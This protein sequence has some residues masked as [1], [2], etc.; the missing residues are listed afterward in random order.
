[1]LDNPT[2]KSID[3]A[4]MVLSI[5]A[6]TII[7]WL[8]VTSSFFEELNPHTFSTYLSVSVTLLTAFSLIICTYSLIF[9][10]QEH[11]YRDLL[12]SLAALNVGID[13]F[14]YWM[15]HPN[16]PF[17]RIIEVSEIKSD[18]L[19]ILGIGVFIFAIVVNSIIGTRSVPVGLER[20]TLI[21]GGLILPVAA[22][23]I[24]AIEYQILMLQFNQALLNLLGD[25]ILILLASILGISLILSLRTWGARNSFLDTSRIFLCFFIEIFLVLRL[26]Q[27]QI[28][29]AIEL[30]A[31]N[32]AL[33][34]FAIYAAST[35]ILSIVEPHRALS[36][37]VDARTRELEISRQESEFYLFMW[38]HDVGNTLQSIASYLELLPRMTSLDDPT[39]HLHRTATELTDKATDIVRLVNQLTQIRSKQSMKL[40]STSLNRVLSESVETLRTQIVD[41]YFRIEYDDRLPQ[42]NVMADELLYQTVGNL[43]YNRYEFNTAEDPFV[44]TDFSVSGSKVLIEVIDNGPPL[45]SDVH[46]SLFDEFRPS[47]TS[48]GLRLFIVRQLITRYHGSFEYERLERLGQNRFTLS[49]A[50]ASSDENEGMALTEVTTKKGVSNE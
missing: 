9:F 20:I 23:S 4:L 7:S 42:V 49:L 32:T 30:W 39:S 37:M 2:Q 46:S 8:G 38:G 5:L 36:E 40:Q 12:F 13:S 31:I 50:L 10:L 43:L 16:S 28:Y 34:G 33:A 48:I 1:M 44:R 19:L 18:T 14:L 27:T 47:M 15:S 17:L 26:L 24:T 6:L 41:R 25:A 3:R 21:A 29:Q 45:P 35:L 11:K 22:I